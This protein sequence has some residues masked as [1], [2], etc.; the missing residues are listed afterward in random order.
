MRRIFKRYDR[1]DPYVMRVVK[2]ALPWTLILIGLDLLIGI[3]P[4]YMF[5]PGT[6]REILYIYTIVVLFAISAI[7][8]KG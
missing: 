5:F 3:Y 8:E 2:R 4:R 1:K 6:P 7:N